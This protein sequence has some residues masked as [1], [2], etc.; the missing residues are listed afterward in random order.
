MELA[1]SGF[2]TELARGA[3]LPVHEFD[4]VLPDALTNDTDASGFRVD[5]PV[6]LTSADIRKLASSPM[7]ILRE[8]FGIPGRRTFGD[9]RVM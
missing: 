5:V 6:V 8:R 1:F 9:L 7:V 4:R 3:S 2:L